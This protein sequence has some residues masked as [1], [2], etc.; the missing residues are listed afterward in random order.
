[1]NRIATWTALLTLLWAPIAWASERPADERPSLRASA[2]ARCVSN[3]PLEQLADRIRGTESLTEARDLAIR[4]TRLALSALSKT[5]WLSP[6]ERGDLDR[7]YVDLVAYQQRVRSAQ[8]S[9]EVA[10]AL[11]TLLASPRGVQAALHADVDV[12]L[13]GGG[14]DYSGGEVIATILGFLL[15]ILPGIILLV[16]LC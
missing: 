16:L 6:G 4:P 3:A 13:D 7:A 12:D 11:E 1:M 5:R 9:N 14:C 10:L 8:T 15:G 2:P